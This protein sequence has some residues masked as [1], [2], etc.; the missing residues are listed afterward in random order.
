MP[1]HLL[2]SA[3]FVEIEGEAA[4]PDFS[5]LH[6][7]LLIGHPVTRKGAATDRFLTIPTK[8]HAVAIAPNRSGKGTGLIIPN[9]LNYGGS[10][11][12][13]DPKG[14][15][16]YITAPQRRRMG[17]RTI[18]LDPWDEVNRRYG[19]KSGELEQVARF[20]PLSIL[21][22]ESPDYADDL[23]YLADALIISQSKNDPFFDD[24]ARDLVAGLMAFC[25]EKFGPRANLAQVRALLRTPAEN[26]AKIAKEAGEEFAARD[27]ESMA[28]HK[29]A[30]FM[31][32]GKTVENIL[33]TARAQLQF[34]DSAPLL[35]NL[36][37]SSFSFDDLTERETT[38]YLVLPVDKLDTKGR[39]LRLMVSIAIRQIARNERVLKSPVLF[40]LDEFGT[41]GRLNAI[42]RAFGLMSGLQMCV[43]AF[44]QDLN[45]LK[46]DYP[47]D[48][49]TF[50]SNTEALA[51]F[52]VMDN[53]SAKYIS[54][55]CG[56]T[57]V[58]NEDNRGGVSHYKR[59]LLTPDE[60][61]R[62]ACALL[63][64][65]EGPFKYLARPYYEDPYF[66]S[67]ARK[68]P[69]YD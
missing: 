42:A 1:K 15:N 55:M 30:A 52:S 13:V 69:F 45:Q 68:N 46:R 4:A 16:A 56:T 34:L 36:E 51:A 33:M 53:F 29:L 19:K 32:A 43:F 21:N 12:V 57:T 11:L 20:N 5:N 3:H 67:I 47:D 10:V 61:R 14:E 7:R 54:E 28:A 31:V 2:G 17:Q 26:I 41:I 66:R 37:K 35:N 25:V 49:E 27:Y 58:I 65:R 40:M 38:I 6:D 64:T 22:P 23:A 60:V 9:L 24:S 8:R 50:I 39:W 18:I 62:H 59:E 48:W 63:L 44:L